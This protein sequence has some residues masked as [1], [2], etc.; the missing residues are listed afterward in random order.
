MFHTAHP[1]GGFTTPDQPKLLTAD[2]SINELAVPS[3]PAWYLK[4]LN[5]NTY[6]KSD[7]F[8]ISIVNG[9]YFLRV[10]FY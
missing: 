10:G 5:N 4:S 3:P 8:I 7:V 6:T 2:K 1:V 9:F